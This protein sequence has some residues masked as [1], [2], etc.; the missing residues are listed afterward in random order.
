MTSHCELHTASVVDK[1]TDVMIRAERK[2]LE[3]ALRVKVEAIH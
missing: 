1:T 2:R 3:A